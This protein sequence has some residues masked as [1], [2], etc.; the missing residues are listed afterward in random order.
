M[1]LTVERW[2]RGRAVTLVPNAFAVRARPA[3]S[4]GVVASGV[5]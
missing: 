2:A 5:S 1:A 3:E 4:G